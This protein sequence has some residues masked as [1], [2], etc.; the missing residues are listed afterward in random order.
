MLTLP[1]IYFLLNCEAL[2]FPKGPEWGAV[3]LRGNCLFAMTQ[4]ANNFFSY[5]SNII[6]S[7]IAQCVNMPVRKKKGTIS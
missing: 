4:V 3:A 6:H 1:C 7:P 5:A 2:H